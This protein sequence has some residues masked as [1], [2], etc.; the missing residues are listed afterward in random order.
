MKCRETKYWLYSLRPNTSWPVDVVTHLQG[1]V[2]CQ[3]V[4]TRLKQ[5]DIEVNKLTTVTSNEPGKA[6]LLEKIERT[7]QIAAQLTPRSAWPF[8]RFA[9]IL[10]A[11]AA[12][13]VLGFFLGRGESG[14]QGPAGPGGAGENRRDHQRS[15]RGDFPRQDHQ[16][17]VANRSQLVRGVCCSGMFAWCNR[18]E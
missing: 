7:P 14:D 3:Q 18:P 13:I 17:P 15:A 8:I 9:G 2:K 5:I 16:S 6:N 12:L 4:Q 10:T 1:C 11:A